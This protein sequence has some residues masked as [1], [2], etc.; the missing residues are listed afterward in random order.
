M[1]QALLY[2]PRDIRVADATRAAPTGIDVEVRVAFCGVCGTDLHAWAGR[3]AGH[4][5]DFPANLGH[6]SAGVISR[7]GEK[8]TRVAVGDRVTVHPYS[9]CGVCHYCRIGM[10]NF[11]E[12]R[13]FVRTGWSE[14]INVPQFMVYPIPDTLSLEA[15]S[16]AEPLAA[17]LQAID[18]AG[19]RSGE[20]AVVLGGGPIGLGVLALARMSGAARVILSEPSPLRRELGIAL[21]ADS[22]VDP[23][24][25]SVLDAV[26][27]QTGGYG[28]D[29]VF[30]CVTSSATTA[31]G[32]S[33]LRNG[34]AVI[35]VG[36][37]AASD[38]LALDLDEVHRRQLTVRGSFSRG[39]IFPRA[40]N[41][42]SRLNLEDMITHKVP[43]EELNAGMQLALDGT[44]GKVLIAL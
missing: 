23:T 3:E 7:V 22:A 44:A 2:A 8:V 30:D 38:R 13:Q 21:G 42:L 36:N 25:E 18:M 40:L 33:M 9:Y 27:N 26:K 43:L 32:I 17:S 1:R 12:A 29:V 16:L 41:W 11:C 20:T 19:M 6:E 24:S 37:V 14:Y 4:R 28:A 35:I 39:F 31:A 5:I 10:Q 34:G 15:A